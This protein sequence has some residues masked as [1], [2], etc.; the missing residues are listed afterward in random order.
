MKP[1]IAVHPIVE[2]VVRSQA[3]NGST[4]SRGLAD[5]PGAAGLNIGASWVGCKVQ[6]KRCGPRPKWQTGSTDGRCGRRLDQ[7]QGPALRCG[8]VT[9]PTSGRPSGRSLRGGCGGDGLRGIEGESDDDCGDIWAAGA[10]LEP[11]EAM[12]CVAAFQPAGDNQA[13]GAVRRLGPLQG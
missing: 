9:A 2:R 8:G 3:E 13:A 6:N 4:R 1:G 12:E 11:W 7:A 5:A 10:C